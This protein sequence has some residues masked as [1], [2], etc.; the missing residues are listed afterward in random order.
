MEKNESE[1]PLH[2]V[3]GVFLSNSEYEL[4]LQQESAIKVIVPLL[5]INTCCSHPLYQESELVDENALGAR[6]AA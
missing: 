2:G 6:H 5:W 1:N 3:F 4:L